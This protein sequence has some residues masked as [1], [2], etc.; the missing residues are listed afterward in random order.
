VDVVSNGDWSVRATGGEIEGRAP[1]PVAAEKLAT[2]IEDRLRLIPGE[3]FTQMQ[4]ER[5]V[6]CSRLAFAGQ[7]RLA[8]PI[9]STTEMAYDVDLMSSSDNYARQVFYHELFHMIDWLDDYEL[10]PDLEWAALNPPGTK[11]GEGG[12]ESRTQ[13]F[14]AKI[15]AGFT[16]WY[17]QSA[18]EEDKAELFAELMTHQRRLSA[19]IEKDAVLEAKV[20]L[21]KKRL[22]AYCS[23][24]DDAWWTKVA[25]AEK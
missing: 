13:P 22:H 18:I 10:S 7:K 6:I 5:I 8:I 12:S 23:A 3:L 21:M 9:Y 20:A 17:A 1:N 19:K 14:F 16:S 24:C 15:S 4:L 11:Y 25:L 2:F